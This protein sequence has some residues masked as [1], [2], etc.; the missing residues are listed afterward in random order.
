MKMGS[1]ARRLPEPHPA[2]EG[3]DISALTEVGVQTEVGVLRD[4]SGIPSARRPAPR[5]GR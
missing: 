1:Q 5:S 3:F 4:E 2:V